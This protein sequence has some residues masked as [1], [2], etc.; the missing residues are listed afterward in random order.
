MKNKACVANIVYRLC[1]NSKFSQ[2]EFDK[3]VKTIMS[4]NVSENIFNDID[5]ANVEMAELKRIIEVVNDNINVV[6]KK[7][8]SRFMRKRM[9]L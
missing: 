3:F 9:T 2:Y 7:V 1:D 4:C 8:G 6:V 5:V